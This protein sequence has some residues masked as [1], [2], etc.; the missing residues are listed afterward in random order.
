LRQYRADPETEITGICC[1]SRLLHPGELFVA[2]PGSREDGHRY[3]PQALEKGAVCVVCQQPPERGDYLLVEDSALALAELS[4]A[5]YGYPARELTLIGITGTNGKTT[6][7]HLTAQLLEKTTGARVGIIGTNGSFFGEEYVPGEN[8][9][10][11]ALQLQRLFRRMADAGCTYAVM[12]VSSHALQ[13]KRTAGLTFDV[14]AFT[15]LSREHLDYH[16]SM[17]EY[18][19]AKGLLF[20]QCLCAVINADDLWQ[21]SVAADFTGKVFTF[22]QRLDAD[23][24]G[25]QSSFFRDRVE[26]TAVSDGGA[27]PAVLHIPGEFSLYNALTALA[28]LQQ[29]GIPLFKST[30]ALRDCCGVRGR[31]EVLPCDRGYTVLVDY[32]HTPDGLENILRAVCAF[33]E[34]RVITVFGCGG[35]RDRGKRPEMARI[36]QRYSDLLVLTSDNPRYE[37][38]Y[39]ILLDILAGLDGSRPFAVLEDRRR[40][41][42]YAMAEARPGDVVLLAGKGHETQQIRGGKTLPFDEREIVAELLARSDI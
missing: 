26:F 19:R 16:G 35:D 7:S 30:A 3:I 13:Q 2:L 14:G 24:V 6:C 8:T 21:K 9:T 23:L 25:W 5:F 33:A 11:D 42:A 39:A 41:I 4:A 29:L 15:N 38:P 40:A 18:A 17:E 34:N 36:S 27:Y 20:S 37:N 32:A 31:A 28:I 22:G 1:D 10:P 12:E